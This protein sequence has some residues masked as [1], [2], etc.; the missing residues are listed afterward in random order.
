LRSGLKRGGEHRADPVAEAFW[1]A[2]PVASDRMT[3]GDHLTLVVVVEDELKF[4][5]VLEQ[6]LPVAVGILAV[7]VV[8]GPDLARDR[9]G[10]LPQLRTLRISDHVRAHVQ[11]FLFAPLIESGLSQCWPALG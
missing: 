7:E 11:L 5:K 1:G 6:A 8:L 10:V 2:V 4:G 9:G 3:L